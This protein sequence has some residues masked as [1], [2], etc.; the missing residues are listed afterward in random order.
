VR[1]I[2]AIVGATLR[3]ASAHGVTIGAAGC[4]F[5]TVLALFPA[6]SLLIDAYGLLLNPRSVEVQMNALGALLPHQTFLLIDR[7][8]RHL[9]LH[10]NR[11]LSIG[12]VLSTLIT[13]FSAAS[14]TRAL[15]ATLGQ[16]YGS[17][18]LA[19]GWRQHV[20]ALGVTLGAIVAAMLA[21]AVLTLMPV[22]MAMLD[23]PRPF[24]PLL[25]VTG[26]LA[27]VG[28][29]GVFLAAL[30]RL[31]LPH[32]ELERRHVVPGAV[33]ATALWLVASWLVSFYAD[34]LARLAATYGP[35]GAV[36]GLMLW[37]YATFYAAL[38]GAEFNGQLDRAM[39]AAP[40]ALR[41][42]E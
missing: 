22:T 40:A 2:L 10:S 24:A 31:A 32:R 15:L 4:A 13:V 41:V 3:G 9:V 39:S 11:T 42:A 27:M 28:L 5:F 6:M 30:Y 8:T 23:F 37:L 19:A 12:I 34:H 21:I 17:S 33:L 26:T 29:G 18:S 38:I 7:W 1:G 20:V 16:S 14:G 36:V 25:H 35:V